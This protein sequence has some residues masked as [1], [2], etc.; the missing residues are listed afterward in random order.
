MVPTKL[1]SDCR[2]GGRIGYWCRT[3]RGCNIERASFNVLELR[4]DR[5]VWIREFRG[6]GGDLS[7][8][9]SA[10]DIQVL[11]STTLRHN[12]FL[13]SLHQWRRQQQKAGEE[14]L[15]SAGH[16][17]EWRKHIIL[18]AGRDAWVREHRTDWMVTNGEFSFRI[19]NDTGQPSRP[20]AAFDLLDPTINP[21]MV[22][23]S[24]LR[25]E[26]GAYVF[27]VDMGT[28]N[29]VAATSIETFYQWLDGI[30]LTEDD[31]ELI[32]IHHAGPFRGNRQEFVAA[33]VPR[34]L[35]E[36]CLSVTFPRGFYPDEKQVAVYH[37][38]L[39]SASPVKDAALRTRLQFTG[40]T[41]LLTVPYPLMD[42]RYVIAWRPPP[43]RPPSPQAKEFQEK[44][45]K[46]IGNQLM[47]SFIKGLGNAQWA[48][49]CTVALYVPEPD[50]AVRGRFSAGRGL[51]AG[52]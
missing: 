29:P 21:R 1:Q 30:L 20:S 11:D 22:G 18:T 19:Q 26:P 10:P 47:T 31:L 42:Y 44:C 13:R 41:I 3:L 38:K 2:C 39:P 25:G 34:P 48:R 36:L 45:S 52:T 28:P 6:P 49:N 4:P 32:D 50:C 16:H 17:S 23:F 46:G 33:S 7:D 43:A 40:Q 37:Q 24:R 15:S 35:R 9:H 51:L 5:S 8:W 27:R 12:R 14:A